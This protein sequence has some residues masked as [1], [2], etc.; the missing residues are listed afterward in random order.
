MEYVWIQTRDGSPT[1]WHNE[2]GESFRSVKGAFTESWTVFVEPA[3]KNCSES[4]SVIQVGEFGLGAGTNWALWTLACAHRGLSFEYTAIE[5]DLKSFEAGRARWIEQ[6]SFLEA[7]LRKK[8]ITLDTIRIAEILSTASVPRVFASLDETLGD[9]SNRQRFRVWFHDPFGFDVNPD[10]Y[11]RETLSKCAQL[12][13]PVFWGGSYACNRHFKE[14]L[15][16]LRPAPH[17]EVASTGD[18][19]LKRERLE[20]HS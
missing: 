16:S 11:S 7:F 18:S 17:I 2:L 6:A 1:L 13:A 5:R 19:G 9:T 4:P 20:F 14:A 3:L 12:W 10:G 15:E 8:S